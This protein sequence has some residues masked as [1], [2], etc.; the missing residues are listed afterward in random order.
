MEHHHCRRRSLTQH[1][2]RQ[3]PKAKRFPAKSMICIRF[4]VI[5]KP[6]FLLKIRI[7]YWF[8]SNIHFLFITLQCFWK[9]RIVGSY[10]FSRLGLTFYSTNLEGSFLL[11]VITWVAFS[12]L[13]L[14]SFKRYNGCLQSEYASA[15]SWHFLNLSIDIPASDFFELGAAVEAFEIFCVEVDAFGSLLDGDSH[16]EELVLG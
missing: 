11:I 7:R 10:N 2:I 13:V 4:I 5:L 3:C 15:W 14:K 9:A 16:G 8:D 1:L 12:L 6:S